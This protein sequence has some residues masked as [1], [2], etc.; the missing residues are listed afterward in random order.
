MYSAGESAGPSVQVNGGAEP[1]P[2]ILY[3]E[4]VKAIEYLKKHKA[5]GPDTIPA[6]IFKVSSE[7][8]TKTIFDICN[9][10]WKTGEWPEDWCK[11][12]YVTLYKKGSP[13]NCENYRTISLISHASKILLKIIYDRLYAVMQSQI[14][15]E[16]AGFTK[17]RGTREQILNMR[18]LIEKL[19]EYNVPAVLCFVDYKKAFDCVQWE[20]LWTVLLEMG[21]PTHLVWIIKQLYEKSS[22]NIRINRD[23]HSDNFHPERGVR[24][25]CILSPLLFNLYGEYI[26]R[27]VLQDVEDFAYG[28]DDDSSDERLV[29]W[30][31]GVSIGG[32]RVTNLRYADDT[33]LVASNVENMTAFL[34]R[35]EEVS[36]EFGLHV[37]RAKTKMMVINRPESNSPDI[38]E[39]EGIEVVNHFTYLG[40][41]VDNSGGCRTEIRRRIQLAKSA[42]GRLRRVWADSAISKTLKIR[43]V[44][45]LVFSVFLYA[46]ET[47]TVRDEDRRRIDALEMWCWRR[48]LRVSWME[49]RTNASILREVGVEKRLSAVVLSRIMRYFGH[50]TRANNIETIFVQG[51]VNGARGRG[52]SPMRWTDTIRKATGHSF[53]ACVRSAQNREEWRELVYRA[54]EQT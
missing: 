32:L 44:N 39:I 20:N 30:R 26:M 53:Q 31:R 3:A 52:R 41:I 12:T 8:A 28:S 4:V 18:Q 5:P 47:W 6:E 33:T 46:S 19:R 24:Q 13:E 45:S 1:E 25:G 42:M 27:K 35:L 40:S 9:T 54:T 34:K 29:E 17:G 7:E 48:L 22:A 15:P 16:Q 10:V 14:P 49:K 2:P 37:N 38:T 11:S 36:A 21:A 50:V 51:K 43:L 23:T